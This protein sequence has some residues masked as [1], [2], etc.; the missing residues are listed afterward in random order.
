MSTKDILM[1]ELNFLRK[2]SVDREDIDNFMQELNIL[3]KYNSVNNSD[4][5]YCLQAII[6][7]CEQKNLFCDDIKIT[8][9]LNK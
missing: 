1:Q 3:C 9:N 7:I 6:Y 5:N 8:F 2:N 4:L